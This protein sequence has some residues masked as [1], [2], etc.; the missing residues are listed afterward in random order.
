MKMRLVSAVFVLAL[1]PL[2]CGPSSHGTTHLPTEGR[3]APTVEVSED[4]F[5]SA[6]RDLLSSAPSTAERQT[7]LEGVLARQMDRAHTLFRK[8]SSERGLT[9]V[10][11]G[12]YLARAGDLQ[13]TTLGP[14]GPEALESA[15]K[16]VAQRG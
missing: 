16:E 4:Q 12:L 6:V 5:A 13:T 10:K 9:A 2:A 3:T 14:H 11:G 15:V 1:A 7:R 8:K